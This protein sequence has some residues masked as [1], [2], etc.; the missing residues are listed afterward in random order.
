MT[1]GIM[2]GKT[3]EQI[4]PRWVEDTIRYGDTDKQG[5]VNNAV[6]STFL[7]TGRVDLLFDPALNLL[8]EG[9]MFVI[10]RLVLDYKRE[11]LWPGSVRIGT[12][13]ERIGRSSV[14]LAQVI[15]QN[16]MICAEAET[17]IVQMDETTRKGR[18]LSQH[19]VEVFQRFQAR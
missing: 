17:T 3:I 16:G 5:H 10:A 4:F 19:A 15:V 6:F 14:L 18:A 1:A 7:E 12:R 2:D 13:V 9:G 8:E 11:I